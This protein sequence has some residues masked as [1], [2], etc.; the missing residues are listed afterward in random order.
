MN[1][2]HILWE[3]K[4][5]VHVEIIDEQHRQLFD[6]TNQLV[7]AWESGSDD[8]FPILKALVDYLSVHFHTENLVMM[9][10]NY[11]SFTSHSREHEAFNEK[12]G[13]FI[14]NYRAE[15]ESLM[16][17]MV[18]FLRSWVLMHTCELDQAYGKQVL[19]KGT[20]FQKISGAGGRQRQGPK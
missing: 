8:A 5:S 4:Y 12:V 1:L 6:I 9:D 7:A 19:K 13:D 20:V 18:A 2:A 16:S 14:R 11:P 15:G 17:D 10:I 3:P